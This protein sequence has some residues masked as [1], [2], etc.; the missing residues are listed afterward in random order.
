LINSRL[1]RRISWWRE[2]ETFLNRLP[3][4]DHNLIGRRS[5]RPGQNLLLLHPHPILDADLIVDAEAS[6]LAKTYC[7]STLTQ[8]LMR[9]FLVVLATCP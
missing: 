6:D 7:C 9:T 1:R 4:I 5:Q 2:F 3:L 8:F